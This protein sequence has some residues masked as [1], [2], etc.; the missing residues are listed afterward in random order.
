MCAAQILAIQGHI[1]PRMLVLHVV[2]AGSSFE[3]YM[4]GSSPEKFTD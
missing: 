4:L 2:V 3:R 1:V